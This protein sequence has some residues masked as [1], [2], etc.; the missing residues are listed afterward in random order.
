METTSEVVEVSAE[1]VVLWLEM[2]R[3]VLRKSLLNDHTSSL[4]T[5]S[6]LWP[7]NLVGW[8]LKPWQGIFHA[9]SHSSKPWK[10]P[11]GSYRNGQWKEKP[12][13]SIALGGFGDQLCRW[14]LARLTG[15][16]LTASFATF[17]LYWMAFPCLL[18]FCSIPLSS[19]L[20]RLVS[21][22]YF[23]F[24]LQLDNK[25]TGRSTLISFP[26]WWKV[27]IAVGFPR[28]PDRRKKLH[29]VGRVDA[30]LDT[31]FSKWDFVRTEVA[32]RNGRRTHFQLVY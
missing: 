12:A 8:W 30:W 28:I 29:I 7:W 3:D 31:S 18:C 14:S 17:S 22:N 1:E 25:R 32:R 9:R 5:L 21:S 26:F 10:P 16:L 4:S 6:L 20:S 19:M 24:L 27:S 15:N 23:L 2:N 11:A 13:H